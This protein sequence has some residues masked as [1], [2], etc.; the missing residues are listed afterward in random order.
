VRDR[1]DETFPYGQARIRIGTNIVIK[2]GEYP[3]QIDQVI[4]LI[5]HGG[6]WVWHI[7]PVNKSP[8]L[9]FLK[10]RP[11]HFLGLTQL[12]FW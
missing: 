2:L 5:R 7:P 10:A 8:R 6:L 1:R 9:A 4:W 3:L 11:G 12:N